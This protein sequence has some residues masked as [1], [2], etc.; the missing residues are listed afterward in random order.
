[1]TRHKRALPLLLL[2]LIGSLVL[3]CQSA[4][5]R[6]DIGM[7]VHSRGADAAEV[8][9]QFD[10]MA[11]MGVKW[12]RVDIGWAFIEHERGRFDWTYTDKVVSEASANGMTVLAVLAT[13]PAWAR[14]SA[15]G[16]SGRTSFYRP[17]SVPDF[18]TFA[19]IAAKR[20][21]LMGVHSWEIWNEPNS[22]RFWPP[23][24]DADEYGA[25]FQAAAEEVRSVDSKATLLIG[26]LSPRYDLSPTEISPVDY[27]EQLYSNG[28]AQRADAIAAHPYSFPAMPADDDQRMIGGFKDLPALHAVMERHGDDRKKIWIT[29]FGAP[30]GTGP[31]AVSEDDQAAA[32]LQAHEEFERWRWAGPLIYYELVNGGTDLAETE[33]NFGVLRVDLSPKPAAVVLMHTASS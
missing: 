29:E 12:V 15:A 18:A 14:S 24:P 10:I 2:A 16:H 8:E 1:M 17:A 22:G 5:T 26:G 31:Y 28:T 20:Y 25:L 30:T 32:I 4:P 33:Q 6:V 11:T 21:A 27:L 19:R 3:S 7:T 9:R 23:R 13:T